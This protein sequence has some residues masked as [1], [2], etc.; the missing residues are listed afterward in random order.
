M[1]QYVCKK[2]AN[3]GGERYFSDDV[4]PAEKIDPSRVKQL[5]DYGILTVVD[6]PDPVVE[7]PKGQEEPVTEKPNGQE[8]QNPPDSVPTSETDNDPADDPADNKPAGKKGKK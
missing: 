3:F 8:G 5:I 4:I 1:K 6:V 7:P 2:K